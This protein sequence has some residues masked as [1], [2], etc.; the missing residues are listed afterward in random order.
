MAAAVCWFGFNFGASDKKAYAKVFDRLFLFTK[1]MPG[2][3]FDDRMTSEPRKIIVNGNTTY[4]RA[5]KSP[6]DISKVLDFYSGQYAPQPVEKVSNKIIEKITDQKIKKAVAASGTFLGLLGRYQHFRMQ[7]GD[8]GFFGALEFRDSGLDIGSTQF[9]KKFKEAL[10]S[11]RIGNFIT[12]RIVMAVRNRGS[13]NTTIINIWTDR[14]FNLNNLKPDPFG[15]MPGKDVDDVPRYPGNKRLLT[16]EQENSSTADTLISYEGEGSLASNILFYHSRMADAGW[17]P[18]PDFEQEM[19]KRSKENVLFYTRKDRECTIQINE[20]EDS[21]KII[22]T[23]ID[24]K[25]NR[26]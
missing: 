9:N 19:R 2:Y 25:G 12:G 24:R 18:D 21:G 17:H 20:D 16:I 15:D 4:L 3:L 11:G 26:G 10:E 23:V 1:T 5:G 8:Y 7:R 22:T 13:G 6:D 14:D